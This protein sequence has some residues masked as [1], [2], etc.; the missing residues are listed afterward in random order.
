MLPEVCRNQFIEI[1]KS[2]LKPEEEQK[3]AQILEMDH[4]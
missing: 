3:N 4:F 1:K 2:A